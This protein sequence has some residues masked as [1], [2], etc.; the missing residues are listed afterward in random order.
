MART[1]VYNEDLSKE[2]QIINP[3]NQ[4]LLN[5][6][7][8]KKIYKIMLWM[9]LLLVSTCIC[10][11]MQ[12][13]FSKRTTSFSD[14]HVSHLKNKKKRLNFFQPPTHIISIYTLFKEL[15]F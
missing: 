13:F 9:S 14:P 1:T 3:K 11:L 7:D 2:W 12:V 4:K 10:S 15:L 6:F 5:K 8:N